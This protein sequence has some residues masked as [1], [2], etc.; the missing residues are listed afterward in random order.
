VR[1]SPVTHS[2]FGSIL[3]TSAVALGLMYLGFPASLW[4]ALSAFFNCYIHYMLD[5]MT[6]QGVQLLYPFTRKAYHIGY[7]RFDDP[8]ANAVLAV[9]A[10][11]MI[12]LWFMQL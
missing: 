12:A 11:M 10:L 4:L 2:V 7:A 1:R 6:A 5:M 9:V 8:Y 3:V